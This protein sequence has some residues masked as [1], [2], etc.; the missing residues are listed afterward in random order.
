MTNIK[1][2][3]MF[4]V[5]TAE[6]PPRTCGASKKDFDMKVTPDSLF[7][8][9]AT[10]PMAVKA[11]PRVTAILWV[12]SKADANYNPAYKNSFE[13]VLTSL[14]MNGT[15][16]KALANFQNMFSFD[17]SGCTFRK[18]HNQDNMQMG[19]LGMMRISFQIT[20][21]ATGAVGIKTSDV[22][23]PSLV[24]WTQTDT[25]FEICDFFGNRALLNTG[26]WTEIRTHQEIVEDN[27]L[28]TLGDKHAACV[29]QILA[30]LEA[31]K[32]EDSDVRNFLTIM[33]DTD[34]ALLPKNIIQIPNLVNLVSQA[35]EIH[36]E[37]LS[38][39]DKV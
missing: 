7:E 33:D 36:H 23:N 17:H 22:E 21:T 9:F 25:G 26:T 8:R 35:Q 24:R 32:I 1:R 4:I 13:I 38:F 37:I 12:S 20:P 11:T 18:L 10:S 6:T 28:N 31:H 15:E 29:E 34:P 2:C 30:L 19:S 39:L 5:A 3:G 27:I 16:K 14:F